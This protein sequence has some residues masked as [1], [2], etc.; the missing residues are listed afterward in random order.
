[1]VDRKVH[2]GWSKPEE[3]AEFC[4]LSSGIG[5][6]AG[7][8]HGD[9]HD[10]KETRRWLHRDRD[11]HSTGSCWATGCDTCAVAPASRSRNWEPGSVGPPPT[12]PRSRTVG[13][14]PSWAC[15]ETWRRPWTVPPSTSWTRPHRVAVSNWRSSCSGPRPD[16]GGPRW[17]SRNSGPVPDL[18]TTYWRYSSAS[19]RPY[20]R[21]MCPGQ[22]WRTWR[23]G[24]VPASP[25]SPCGPRCVPATTTSPR[26][27]PRRWPA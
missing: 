8:G 18:T 27:R 19:T 6:P 11:R 20:P 14:S 22:G 26:S 1:M 7:G 10:R 2:L 17:T 15:W 25:T 9:R 24:I 12:C 4:L 5:W 13:S 23:P 16:H 3:S 21:W